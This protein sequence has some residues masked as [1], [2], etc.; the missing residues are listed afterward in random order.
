MLQHMLLV[1]YDSAEQSVVGT[2]KHFRHLR[3]VV[4]TVMSC[5]R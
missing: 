4:I 5:K 1:S 2:L 3:N